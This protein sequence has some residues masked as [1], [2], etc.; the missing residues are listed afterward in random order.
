MRDEIKI[1]NI[2][3]KTYARTKGFDEQSIEYGG[4][5]VEGGSYSQANLKLKEE[6][7][8]KGYEEV[9]N[10]TDIPPYEIQCRNNPEK[11]KVFG[12]R[13]LGVRIKREKE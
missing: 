7:K 11:R 10:V 4:L 1:S 6:A 3:L 12:V 8:R 9:I 13:A 5:F 2:N